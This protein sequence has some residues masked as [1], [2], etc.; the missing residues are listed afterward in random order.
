MSIVYNILSSFG[1]DPDW[2][3]GRLRYTFS[4]ETRRRLVAGVESEFSV[5]TFREFRRVRDFTD[6]E[7]LI[8]EILSQLSSDDV[9]FDI[10]ANIGTHSCFAGQ[11][12]DH[13][14]SF[15]PHPET[16]ERLRENLAR[17]DVP[18]TVYQLALSDREGTAELFRPTDTAEEL[19]S[20]EFSLLR[21]DEA[22]T[23]WKVDV[24]PG[25]TLLA[26]DEI[27]APDVVKIDVEGAELQVIDGL[28]ESLSETRVVYCEVHPEHVTVEEITARLESVGFTTELVGEREGGHSFLRAV[29]EA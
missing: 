13:I 17:N 29:C 8:E 18:A 26:R 4:P 28:A 24:V 23:S 25:D 22:E 5:G 7:P 2:W 10:G 3:L 11:V 15:E 6:E 14:Y 9:F 27:P 12:A 19:G 1:V 20:G 16:A 21:G